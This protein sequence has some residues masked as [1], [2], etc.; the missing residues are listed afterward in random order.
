MRKIRWKVLRK[1]DLRSVKK[2]RTRDQGAKNAVKYVTRGISGELCYVNF[3]FQMWTVQCNSLTA[4]GNR[5]L[6]T[7]TRF[8]PLSD[9]SLLAN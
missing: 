4:V 9:L 2:V 7:C 8:F 3:A 1:L 6:K 5:T